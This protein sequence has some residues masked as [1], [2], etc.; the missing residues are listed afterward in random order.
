MLSFLKKYKI[1]VLLVL[2]AFI[3]FTCSC[4]TIMKFVRNK[5]NVESFD[6]SNVKLIMF[7]VDWCPYCKTALPVFKKIKDN[8]DNVVVNNKKIKV[9]SLDCTDDTEKIPEFN[10]NTIDH[11]LNNFKIKGTKYSIEGYPTIVLADSNNNIISE[12]DKNTTYDNI[13]TFI[14]S[15]L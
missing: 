8:Y 3:I 4:Y 5:G 15:S 2:L 1:T 13:E 14:N 6:N 7:H 12:F 10:N 11:I 9:I